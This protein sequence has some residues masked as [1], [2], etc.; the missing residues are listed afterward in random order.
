MKWNRNIWLP[1]QTVIVF[2]HLQRDAHEWS[3]I[4]TNKRKA[5]TALPEQSFDSMEE[6][7]RCYGTSSSYHLHVSGAGVLTRMVDRSSGYKDDLTVNG[8]KEDFMFS[9]FT[10][11]ERSAVSFLRK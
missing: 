2:C 3:A 8:S 7:I 1:A 4:R 5:P 9:S 6:L 11:Q 10:D